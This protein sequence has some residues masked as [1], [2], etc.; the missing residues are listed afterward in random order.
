MT[1]P[2][3]FTPA[4]TVFNW[5]IVNLER[6]TIDGYVLSASYVVSAKNGRCLA[7]LSGGIGLPRPQTKLIPFDSLTEPC[8]VQWIKDALGQ[9]EVNQIEAMLQA[10]LVDKHSSPRAVGLPWTLTSTEPLQ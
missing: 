4:S 10:Q 2:S 7:K 8:V 3:P 5:T 9:D 1:T 6:E